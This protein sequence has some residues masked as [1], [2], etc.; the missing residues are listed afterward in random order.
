MLRAENAHVSP[1]WQTSKPPEAAG[2]VVTYLWSCTAKDLRHTFPSQHE[3][4]VITPCQQE[5][6]QHVNL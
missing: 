2:P 5:D 3:I 4:L 1:Q 6:D